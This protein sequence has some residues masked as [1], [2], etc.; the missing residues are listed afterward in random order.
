MF[1]TI[2]FLH[3]VGEKGGVGGEIVG[4]VPLLV[5]AFFLASIISINPQ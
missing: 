5:P 1:Y 4:R 3:A 2:G